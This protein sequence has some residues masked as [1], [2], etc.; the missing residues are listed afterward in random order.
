MVFQGHLF[1]KGR[2]LS[3]SGLERHPLNPMTD[4]DIRRWLGRQ[5]VGDVGLVDYTIVRQ[6]P[7]AIAAALAS[8]AE[9][10]VIVDATSDEDLLAIGRAA[11][12]A[13]LITGGSG[14]A[15]AL[16]EM[17]REQ[18]LLEESWPEIAPGVP[19][20]RSRD[21]TPMAMALKSGNFGDQ[22][23]FTKSLQVLGTDEHRS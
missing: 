22:A 2:L 12:K 20:L 11:R 10:L 7:A 19:A 8:A 18:G 13:R 16:P 21:E 3:E 4:S 5:T 15:M 9:T 17:F 23:F 14:I 6:G 1:V